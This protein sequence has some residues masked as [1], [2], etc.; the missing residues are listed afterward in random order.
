LRCAV[1][2]RFEWLLDPTLPAQIKVNDRFEFPTLL[3]LSPYTR[4]YLQRKEHAHAGVTPG[5]PDAAGVTPGGPDTVTPGGPDSG[6][7]PDGPTPTI[8]AGRDSS[9]G[10]TVTSGGSYPDLDQPEESVTEEKKQE[11]AERKQQEMVVRD[12]DG[13]ALYR[14]TGILVHAGMADAGHYYSF[15]RSDSGMGGGVGQSPVSALA[16]TRVPGGCSHPCDDT[17]GRVVRVQ[18]YH[19]AP[20]RPQQHPA[21]VLRWQGDH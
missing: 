4:D 11:R 15:I 12:S 16:T 5:G 17:A 6:A 10:D 9:A 21:A 3:D 1:A 2:S 18:R 14:L 19:R 7:T 8:A 13:K 20:V